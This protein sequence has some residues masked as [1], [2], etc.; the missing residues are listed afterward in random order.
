[1]F[2]IQLLMGGIIEDEDDAPIKPRRE[3]PAKQSAALGFV[4]TPATALLQPLEIPLS[5]M[6]YKL[7][8]KL[9]PW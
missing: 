3:D 7:K 5:S 1:M 6:K 9:N 8:W 2:V 4:I